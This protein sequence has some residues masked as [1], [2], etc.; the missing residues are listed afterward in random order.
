MTVILG[1]FSAAPRSSLVVMAATATLA[2]ALIAPIAAFAVAASDI[3][4]HA[5]S[6]A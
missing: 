5:L 2:N 6:K 4:D 1:A 3:A